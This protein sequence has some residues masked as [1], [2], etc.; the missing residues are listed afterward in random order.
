MGF[1]ERRIATRHVQQGHAMFVGN[2]GKAFLVEIKDVSKGGCRIG[3]PRTWPFNMGD[4]GTIYIFGDT[5][6]V[7]SYQGRIAWYQEESVGVEFI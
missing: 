2:T 6:P 4:V 3:R 5:G 7:P 1:F